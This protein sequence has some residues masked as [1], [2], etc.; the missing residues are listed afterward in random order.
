MKSKFRQEHKFYISRVNMELLRSRLRCAMELDEH[1]G[2]DG[3]YYIRSLY[4]DD[5]D[6]TAF[7]EKLDGIRDRCKFRI[8]YYN[9]DDSYIV[10][11]K[12]ERMGDLCRKTSQRITR[13]MAQAMMEGKPTGGDSPLIMEF[14]ALRAGR[15]LRPAVIVDYMR[16]A[17]REPVSDVRVTLDSQLCTPVYRLEL[18]NREL[19]LYPVFQRDEALIELK[20]D[21]FAPGYVKELLEGIPKV[22]MAVSKYTRCLEMMAE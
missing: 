12:K 16:Y 4:F 22:K 1:A 5:T 7:R 8:R 9:F 14:D 13:Q 15:G 21:E 2:P 20:F 6:K 18:F 3:G 10:L 17:F 19:P 11:E